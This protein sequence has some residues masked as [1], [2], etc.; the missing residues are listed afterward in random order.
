MRARAH[1]RPIGAVLIVLFVLGVIALIAGSS[2]LQAIGGVVIVLVVLAI[3][4]PAL[5]ASRGGIM[6]SRRVLEDEPLVEREREGE[7]EAI[8]RGEQDQA[9]VPQEEMDR[10]WAHE[11]ELYKKRL[12]EPPE[13]S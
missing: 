8:A 4:M 6:T 9:P 10:A 12:S 3:A 2:T 5:S 1:L 11:E 13:S 7:A